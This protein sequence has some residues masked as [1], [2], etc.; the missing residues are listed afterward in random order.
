MPNVSPTSKS[1]E[2]RSS[3][4]VTHGVDQP[5]RFVYAAILSWGAVDAKTKVTSRAASARD[6]SRCPRTW[7]IPSRRRPAN[8]PHREHRKTG[9]GWVVAGPRKDRSGPFRR[10]P[11]ET[12]SRSALPPSAAGAARPPARRFSWRLLFCQKRVTDLLPLLLRGDLWPLDVFRGCGRW[13]DPRRFV[14]HERFL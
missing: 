10:R 13:K 14:R 4:N 5:T 12:C 3:G 1:F 11:S 7:S 8:S 9:R 2:N 6:A